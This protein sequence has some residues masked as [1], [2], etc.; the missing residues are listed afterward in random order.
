M[1]LVPVSIKK[2]SIDGKGVFADIDIPKRTIVWKFTAG[3]DQVIT[4]EE[5]E[6]LDESI[7]K[8]MEKVAYLSPSSKVWISPPKDDPACYTNHSRQNNTTVVFDENISPEPYFV[9]NRTINKGE[10][11]T[12]SYSE[13]DLNTR[14]QKPAWI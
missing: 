10:E 2:S 1:Y 14:Q 5:F 13:F 11:I 12:N 3:Y 4:V 7:R 6:A 9:A 8:S